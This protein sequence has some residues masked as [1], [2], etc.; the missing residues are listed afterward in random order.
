[1]VV[2]GLN[3]LFMIMLLQDPTHIKVLVY[4]A[5]PVDQLVMNQENLVVHRHRI[6][7]TVQLDMEVL[8]R[9]LLVH[10][11]IMLEVV[12]VPVVHQEQKEKEEMGDHLLTSLVL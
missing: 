7:W 3:H 2:L 8:D 10:Q 11:L 9:V 1:M 12:A 4:L 5:V 6:Q